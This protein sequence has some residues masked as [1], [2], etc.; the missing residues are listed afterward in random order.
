M[1]DHVNIVVCDLETS[2]RFYERV[3][4]LERG[5]SALLEGE[6][7]AQVTGLPHVRARCLFLAAPDGETRIELLQYE[8][9]P[10]EMLPANS[11]PNTRGLRHLALTCDGL[12]ALL[13]RLQELGVTP[14][15]PPVEVPF[16]VGNLGRKRLCY[17]HDPDGTLLEAAAYG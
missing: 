6:W 13:G 9:P 15:S 1:I 4:G 5:F 8:M 11:L 16:K 10:G 7:I 17:F 3:F 2:A 14:L 12:D